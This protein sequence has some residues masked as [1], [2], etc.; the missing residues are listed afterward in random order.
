MALNAK[1]KRILARLEQIK[2]LAA[3]AAV[4]EKKKL[5]P[6][7]LEEAAGLALDLVKED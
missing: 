3:Q 7:L 5:D 6:G 4:D 2:D 1:Q